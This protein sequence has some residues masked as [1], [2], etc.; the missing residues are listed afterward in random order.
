MARAGTH[1]GRCEIKVERCSGP[2][3]LGTMRRN[4]NAVIVKM[5]TIFQAGKRSMM[6]QNL[7]GWG[8]G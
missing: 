5:D 7:D 4:A 8:R 2:S 1:F 3:R 6:G